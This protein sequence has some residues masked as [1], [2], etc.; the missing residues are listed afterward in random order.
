VYKASIRNFSSNP[1]RR[2]VFT[3]GIGYNDPISFAQEIALRVLAEHP[4][5]LKHPE[6]W[7]LVDSLGSSTVNLKIYFWLNG[8][9]HSWLKVRSSVIRLVK[10]SFQE[11]GISMP[12]EA[13]EVV[14]PDGVTVTVRR[15]E[16]DGA[17]IQN[18]RPDAER[19]S[20]RVSTEAEAGLA[21]EADDIRGQAQQARTPDD[22]QN[23]LEHE[24][25]R[26]R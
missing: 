14:F 6:P 15:G 19:E 22:G 16:A 8:L 26:D 13:R 5:V 3:V 18:T 24:P 25:V 11:H 7:V 23:L 12:D 4:A 1:N 21:T 20:S 9:E 2:E 17:A 10:R